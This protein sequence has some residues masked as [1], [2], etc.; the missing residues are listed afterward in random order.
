MHMMCSSIQKHRNM[1]LHFLTLLVMGLPFHNMPLLLYIY[2]Q[3]N[4]VSGA[5]RFRVY[6]ILFYFQFCDVAELVIIHKMI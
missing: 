2:N 3:E 5:P 1:Y 6:L 4:R